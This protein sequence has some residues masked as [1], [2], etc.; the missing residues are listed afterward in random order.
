MMERDSLVIF[1]TGKQFYVDLHFEHLLF[2]LL[3]V[4]RFLTQ[5]AQSCAKILFETELTLLWKVREALHDRYERIYNYMLKW[6]CMEPALDI[7][8][9]QARI[10]VP[11]Q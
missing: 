5:N 6:I 11:S 1:E 7:G 8:Q 4:S 9:I 3:S 10:A 2:P